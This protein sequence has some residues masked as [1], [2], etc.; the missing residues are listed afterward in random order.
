MIRAL[1]SQV[2]RCPIVGDVRYNWTPSTVA[3]ASA[4]ASALKDEDK[5][6]DDQRR[7][8][9]HRNNAN[10]STTT[11]APVL[12]DRS[13]ALHAYVIHFN[14][15]QLQLGSLDTYS[16]RAPIPSTWR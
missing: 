12:R 10:T 5:E 2:G 6:E 13:V 15:K 16:F 11:T 14:P 9:N 3:S 4:S 8:R 7:G 1:L